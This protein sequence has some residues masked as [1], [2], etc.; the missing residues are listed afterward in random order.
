MAAIA[1]LAFLAIYILHIPFPLIILAAGLAG[2]AGSRAAPELF[3]SAVHGNAKADAHGVVDQMFERGDLAHAEP[4]LRRAAGIIAVWLPVWLGPVAVL[5][6]ALGSDSVWTQIGSF[7]SLMDWHGIEPDLP[8][9]SSIDRRAAVL[10][11]V[12]MFAMFRLKL[13]ML[14]TL[15]VCGLAGM[16]LSALG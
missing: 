15:A 14:P 13:E 4:S 2:W 3:Q 11:A 6:A 5:W 1:G 8:L 7:F 16:V 9:L 10:A 12:A